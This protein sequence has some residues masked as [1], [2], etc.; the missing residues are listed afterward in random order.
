MTGG[1]EGERIARLEGAYA[2]LATKADIAELRAE[3]RSLRWF[4]VSGIAAAGLLVAAL[5]RLVA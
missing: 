1:T 3:L 4:I 5:N 2:H